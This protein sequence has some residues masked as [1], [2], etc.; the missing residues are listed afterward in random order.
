MN[1]VL[2][3]TKTWIKTHLKHP[4]QVTRCRFSPCGRYLFAA[5]L[6][7][8]LYRWELATEQITELRGHTGW[9][10]ALAFH[11]DGKRLYSGDYHGAVHC[12]EYAAPSPKPTASNP[13]GCQGWV[14]TLAVN[15]SGDAVV[16]G[17]CGGE[18]HL[19]GANNLKQRRE[20]KGHAG[21]VFSSTFHPD[22]N[23]LVTGDL[24]GRVRHWELSSGRCLREIDVSPLHTR[25]EEFLADVGGVR[26]LA[27][28]PAGT[29]L[30]CGGI[31]DAESNTFCPGTPTVLVVN[32]ST[33]KVEHRLNCPART[34]VDGFV[35]ALRYLPDGTLCGY[36]EGTSG[37]A[38]WFWKPGQSEPFHSLAGPTGYD[39]DL[40]PDGITLAAALYENRGH[41]GNGRRAKA[42]E[43]YV[44]N[45]GIVRIFGLYARPNA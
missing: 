18:L 33:G 43:E 27:F 34:K 38:L 7:S 30:A 1:P 24:F 10:G 25:K 32:W 41:S 40:H 21:H 17:G 16:A 6:E 3:P 4:R 20:L 22:R 23:T 35:N 42:P 31:T 45:A 26:S 2:D 11:P 13:R 12:W 36:A 19:L 15:G 9:I 8:T 29:Y 37:A 44:P 14:R 5:G 39:L 28:H